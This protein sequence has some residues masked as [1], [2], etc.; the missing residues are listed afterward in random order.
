MKTTT[1]TTT[2]KKKTIITKH[3]TTP[4]QL[5][6]KNRWILI[7]KYYQQTHYQRRTIIW[8]YYYYHYDQTDNPNE[9]RVPCKSTGPTAKGH[10]KDDLLASLFYHTQSHNTGINKEEKKG[11]N[12][13]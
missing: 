12:Y 4:A 1:T 3:N 2:T 7:L 13:I 5:L 10:K 8:Y 6:K 11:E 9:L